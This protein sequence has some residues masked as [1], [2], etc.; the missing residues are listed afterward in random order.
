MLTPLYWIDTPWPGRLAI[1]PRPRGGDW[2]G[3]E[4]KA[5]RGAGIDGVVSALTPEEM[6]DLDLTLEEEMC[7]Q[8]GLWFENF[9]I[10]D[11]DA[12]SSLKLAAAVLNRWDSGLQNGDS[13]VIHCRQGIG[14]SALLAA[15][16]LAL[17]GISMNEAWRRIE[18]SRGAK[19]PDTPEQIAWVRD[20]VSNLVTESSRPAPLR[21]S[22]GI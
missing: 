14:R 13:I 15:A 12:P 11:R 19:V 4:L 7:S 3:D 1:A 21:R 17:G 5:W 10:A 18:H 20:F 22:D 8:S 16:L 2:L 6:S 9:P